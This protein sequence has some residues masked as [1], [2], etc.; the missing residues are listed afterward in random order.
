MEPASILSIVS[1]CVTLAIKAGTIGKDAASL[2]NT[3]KEA[4]TTV[5]LLVVRV[6]ALGAAVKHISNWVSNIPRARL[7][8]YANVIEQLG[9][10]LTSCDE[11]L[12]TLGAS[13]VKVKREKLEGSGEKTHDHFWKSRIAYWWNDNSIKEQEDTLARHIEALQL[14]LQCL[15]L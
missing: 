14:L 5:R 15:M 3:L 13:I 10:T 12:D 11:A 6:N 7:A 1:A 9:F 2:Y 8:E 4:P